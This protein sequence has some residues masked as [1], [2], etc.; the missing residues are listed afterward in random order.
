[1]SLDMTRQNVSVAG[2]APQA[3]SLLQTL[4]A[5]PRLRESQHMMPVARSQGLDQFRIRATRENA[6]AAAG[7]TAA[8]AASPQVVAPPM[9]VAPPVRSDVKPDMS[10]VKK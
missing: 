8:V 10:G 2:E 1:M 3:D 9:A 4:D 5:S 7:G 6:V